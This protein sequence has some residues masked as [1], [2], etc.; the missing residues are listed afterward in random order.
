MN[1]KPLTDRLDI[2]ITAEDKQLFLDKCEDLNKAPQILLREMVIAVTQGRL[3]I[4][5]SSEEINKQKEIYNVD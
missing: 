3:K 4:A 2:R 1:K 5:V